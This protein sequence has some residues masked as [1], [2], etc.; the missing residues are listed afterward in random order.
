MNDIY[1][2]ITRQSA[3]VPL[4]GVKAS[5]DIIGRGA[6]IKISQRFKN[7]EPNPVEAVYKF[8]LPEGSAVCGFS[9]LVN[10]RRITGEVEEKD[11]AFEK[12]DQALTKG[13]GGYLLD[14]ERPNI[15]TLSVGNL[16]PGSEVLVELEYVLLL[17]RDMQETRFI[18]PTTIS[19]RYLPAD[20]PDQDGIPVDDQLHPEYANAVPYGL[21]IDLVIH[22]AASIK[23]VESPSHLINLGFDAGSMRVKFISEQVKMDRDF[24][25]T[26]LHG[27]TIFNRAYRY[28]DDNN[29]FLQLDLVPQVNKQS[30]DTSNREIVFVLDCSGS[31]QGDSIIQ[32]KKGLEVCLKAL[33]GG[34]WFNLYRFGSQFESL[35]PHS[36][37]YDEKSLGEGLTYLTAS[38]ADLGGT[39]VVAPLEHIYAKSAMKN[40][41]RQII[42]LT[43]GEVGNEDKVMALV[44]SHVTNTRFFTIGIGTGPN[45]HLIRGLAR[46]GRGTC[47]FIYPG[48]RIE[49]K[50]LKIF[51]RVME[52]EFSAIQINWNGSSFEQAPAQLSIFAGNSA[53]VF[54]R[55]SGEVPEHVTF[56][57]R[58]GEQD[59]NWEIPVIETGIGRLPVPVLWARERIRDLEESKDALMTT[60]SRQVR[61]KTIPWQEAVIELSKAYGLL[62]RLT[63]YVA[64]E[65]RKEEDKTTGELV[66]RKVPSLVT[67][68]WHGMDGMGR[69]GMPPMATQFSYSPSA[70]AIIYSK[71]PD[72]SEF[73]KDYSVMD[74]F[75]HI[76]DGSA[77]GKGSKRVDLLMNLLSLQCATGGFDLD[78]KTAKEIGFSFSTLEQIAGNSPGDPDQNL[79]I[80]STA[81]ILEILEVH[82]QSERFTWFGLVKKSK[83]WLSEILKSN[84]LRVEGEDVVKWA[85]KFVAG[86]VEVG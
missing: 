76:P 13:D 74:E 14:Q 69:T 19:P 6:R 64:V 23:S 3:P 45:E 27:D 16:N 75:S 29:V 85:G 28:R 1:G 55:L 32:A 56:K 46:A 8:P 52:P 38:Q 44:K 42:L 57:A 77:K 43:D 5:G 12:Y 39:E 25:L 47:E 41:E 86:E 79:R 30:V 26:I 78:S 9:V 51:Q 36:R 58:M 66:L 2:L 53:S 68:G 60:G 24:V 70:P 65:E 73:A 40:I 18:L 80:L 7:Q 82:F 84:P 17:D 61:K 59:I 54:V 81:V 48:E 10:G 67:Y 62:S 83:K 71:F 63:S 49:H 50:M 72:K 15:F 31:M 11:K 35:F 37:L 34:C 33:P 22:D 4:L 21:C 20:T